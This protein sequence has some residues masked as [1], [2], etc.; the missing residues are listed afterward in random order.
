MKTLSSIRDEFS[1][2]IIQI[3][4]A[5]S[6]LNALSKTRPACTHV[7]VPILKVD[8]SEKE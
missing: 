6:H 1:I 4:S 8:A 5:C 7:S 3:H 2:N